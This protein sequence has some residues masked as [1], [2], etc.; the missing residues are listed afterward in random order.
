MT[1]E[2]PIDFSQ[3]SLGQQHELISLDQS[4]AVCQASLA[5]VR[6]AQRSVIII[7]RQLDA[8]LYNNS[9][10]T[11]AVRDFTLSSRHARLRILVQDSGPAIQSGHGLIELSQRLSSFIEIRIPDHQHANYNYAFLVVDAGGYLYREQ[12]DLYTAHCS[13]ADRKYADE[14]SRKFEDI[15][16]SSQPDVNLRRM[17]M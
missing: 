7:S 6:Q 12:A 4:E 1:I 17:L 11:T 15:W 2:D 13:F 16:E 8:R 14:L 5:L 3:Y 10:F 9:E